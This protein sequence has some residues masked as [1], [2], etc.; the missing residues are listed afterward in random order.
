MS[1]T[2]EVA[3][4]A[5]VAEPAVF[6]VKLSFEYVKEG[7]RRGGDRRMSSVVVM[8]ERA[9]FFR[10]GDR[11]LLMHLLCV[12]GTLLECEFEHEWY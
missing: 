7:M 3:E 11:L 2:Q 4:V 9:M 12:G 8:G 1:P 5:E 6:V 10:L